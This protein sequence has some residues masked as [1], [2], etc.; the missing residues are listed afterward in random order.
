MPSILLYNQ[1]IE[2][3]LPPRGHLPLLLLS[4][5]VLLLVTSV[6]LKRLHKSQHSVRIEL[7]HLNQGLIQLRQDQEKELKYLRQTL[8]QNRGP[9]TDQ[10]IATLFEEITHLPPSLLK[11]FLKEAKIE[12]L[13]Q[14]FQET[15]VERQ[16]L[17]GHCLAKPI[18]KKFQI[19]IRDVH[20][21]P[22]DIKSAKRQI[23]THGV[24]TGLLLKPK[25]D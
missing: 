4:F 2:E 13:V 16:L 8:N 7:E 3:F 1:F 24:K 12:N 18:A 15:S 21:E 14:S 22:E 17:I 25:S 10:E 19:Q 23:I 20:I 5:T 6:L 9:I 11:Q